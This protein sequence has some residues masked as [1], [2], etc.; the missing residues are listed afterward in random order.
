MR[1]V[2]W[3]GVFVI[4]TGCGRPDAPA[5]KGDPAGQAV[6]RVITEADKDKAIEL[7]VGQLA[8]LELPGNP[9][10]GYRWDFATALDQKIL[11]YVV[12]VYR[13]DQTEGRVGVGGTQQWILKAVG[14]GKTTL[15]LAYHRPWEKET[16]PAQTARFNVE[17]KG[18]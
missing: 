8:R 1:K 5:E 16:P 3:I 11:H 10:T 12:D 7:R 17:V 18:E 2:I 14:P 6:A 13:A 15:D 9:T 4:A